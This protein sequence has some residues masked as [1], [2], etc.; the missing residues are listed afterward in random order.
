M[1]ESLIA[2]FFAWS[3]FLLLPAFALAG[4]LRRDEKAAQAYLFAI[5]LHIVAAVVY[6]YVPGVLPPRGDA[7]HFHKIATALQTT[8][9]WPFGLSSTLYKW[10]LAY[11]YSWVGPS[12]L[13]ASTIS[14]YA[15]A[16]S[17]IVLV[18]FMELLDV[19]EGKGLAI[20]L[21]GA[22]PTAVLYGSVPMREP[23]QVLFCMTSCYAMLRFRK[24]GN[25]IYLLASIVFAVL[26][27]MLHKGLLI[28]APFMIIIMLLVSSDRDAG[29]QIS[30]GRV[31]LHRLMAVG[32]AAGLLGAMSTVTDKLEGVQGTAVLTTVTNEGVTD[33]ASK[34]RS[35]EAQTKGRTAYGVG[36]DASTP[37]RFVI[38]MIV[39]WFHYMFVPLPWQVRNLMDIMA[40]SEVVLR[41][42]TMYAIFRV[43]WSGNHPHRQAI[44]M[45][46]LVYMTMAALWASGTTTYGT[47]TRHHMVHQWVVVVLGVPALLQLMHGTQHQGQPSPSPRAGQTA[48]PATTPY[49]R[50]LG[51]TP[52]NMPRRLIATEKRPKGLKS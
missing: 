2:D 36:M 45:L 20:L 46:M 42:V 9:L 32:L 29:K 51:G 13:F 21:F 47:A 6:V 11:V 49:L 7:V 26:M 35:D 27:G 14:M 3:S 40:F 50:R 48:R 24:G 8:D 1:S 16:L 38:S 31:W 5:F 28:F 18:K 44:V 34:Y 37:T 17:V 41:A 25:P 19:R 4:P 23:F 10:C 43:W 22:L 33:L 39:I 15:F 30:K 12:W 52:L